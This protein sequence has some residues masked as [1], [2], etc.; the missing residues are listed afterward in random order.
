MKPSDILNFLTPDFSDLLQAS[1]FFVMLAMLLLTVISVWRTASARAWEKKW[2][3]ASNAKAGISQGIE[4]GG[5]TD[6]FHIVA[7][8]PEKLAEV[9]P[10]MLLIVGLL[11]TFIG[12]GL[13]LD[14]ASSILGASTAM[15]AAGAADG[16]QN[17]LGMLKGLGTKFKTS[18]WGIT[19]FILMKVWS[20]VTQFD[21]KRLA[22]VIGKVKQESETR[23]ALLAAVEAD[24][25][26]RSEQL[27]HT[28]TAHLANAFG[29]GISR[30][31]QTAEENHRELVAKTAEYL[32]S[33]TSELR[34]QQHQIATGNIEAMRHIVA[35]QNALHALFDSTSQAALQSANVRTQREEARLK[36]LFD[37][38]N[39]I[40][41]KNADTLRELFDQHA[42]AINSQQESQHQEYTALSRRLVDE[43]ST[44][45]QLM[46]DRHSAAVSSSTQNMGKGIEKQLSEL[47]LQ[48]QTLSQESSDAISELFRDQTTTLN[49]QQKVDMRDNTRM[50]EALSGDMKRVAQ[51]SLQTNAA[52]QQFTGNTQSVIRNMDAAAQRM[53]AGADKVGTSALNLLDAVSDFKLQFTQVLENV[54]TDLGAAIIS[55]SS[56]S[57]ETLKM[58]SD[59]LSAATLQISESLGRLSNDVT[60]TMTEVKTSIDSALA[61]Q[62]TTSIEF[63]K[64]SDILNESLLTVTGNIEKLAK[65]IDQGLKTISRES[66]RLRSEVDGA[67]RDMT[68]AEKVNDKL[69]ELNFS[70]SHFGDIPSVIEKLAISLEPIRDIHAAL[71]EVHKQLIV[72]PAAETG[73]AREINDRLSSA[74]SPLSGIHSLLNE[75]RSDLA[76]RPISQPGLMPEAVLKDFS[77]QIQQALANVSAQRALHHAAEP[78]A[79][80]S[81]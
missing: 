81:D 56:Q 66:A 47:I 55:M 74:L 35:R 10:G 21:E 4:Q 7:T 19:G 64:S 48:Q 3:R 79:V 67:V 77:Q 26:K 78:T 31:V 36:T 14:K 42:Q 59:K 5:V 45:R 51:A 40:A 9:M 53:S 80:I 28:M 63:V 71:D 69:A 32:T 58:G 49:E 41:Q 54:R 15:D 72:R 39:H 30:S 29:N 46:F 70:L 61:I 37:Q 20:E 18:T 38:Q 62:R 1:F 27:G 23:N 2:N 12:L 75:L 34:E 33:Q 17:M 57:S 73:I 60:V 25:W 11:G 43:Q 22:W 68:V 44:A 52:M 6:L 65:P 8:R 50:I 16:L 76:N 24:K 13:A